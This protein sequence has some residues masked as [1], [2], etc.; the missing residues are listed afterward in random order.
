M[1]FCKTLRDKKP[2]DKEFVKDKNVKCWF[3]D[4]AKYLERKNVAGVE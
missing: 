3:D 2:T 1:N 4:F